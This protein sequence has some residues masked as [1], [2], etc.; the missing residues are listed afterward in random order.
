[1]T[2]SNSPSAN[3]SVGRVGLHEGQIPDAAGLRTVPALA[4]GDH[5][6]REVGGDD[7]GAA[8]G[9]RRHSSTPCRRRGR[10][11]ADLGADARRARVV[12]ARQNRSLPRLS[13]V[14]VRSYPAATWSNMP[15]TRDGSLRRSA[16]F[17]SW[18]EGWDATASS[19]GRAAGP[20]GVRA[21]RCGG[22]GF[23]RVGGRRVRVTSSAWCA[24]EVTAAGCA[25]RRQRGQPG[26]PVRG[27]RVIERRDG[28]RA[29]ALRAR[30]RP[31]RAFRPGRAGS[32]RRRGARSHSSRSL[33]QTSPGSGTPFRFEVQAG[34][35][36]PTTS[37]KLPCRCRSEGRRRRHVPARRL[38]FMV[39][40][41][42]SES[43][44]TIPKRSRTVAP[45]EV[46]EQRP[47][48]VAR[49]GRRPRDRPMA[50]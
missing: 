48:E 40:S 34:R 5:A 50:A 42:V 27:R 47:D 7:L 9:E 38:S 28:L 35:R 39:R 1:M 10:G 21:G 32:R 8:A 6:R 36:A 19:L 23:V 15:L 33:I 2:V 26:E 4:L 49:A 12:A 29:R 24:G 20:G 18:S 25:T 13:T 14:F 16:R 44:R 22:G 11:C 43:T 30:R 31:T 3:G 45:F 37:K 41:G 17:G 46:V